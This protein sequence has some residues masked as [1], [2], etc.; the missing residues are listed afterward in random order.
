MGRQAGQRRGE[1]SLARRLISFAGWPHNFHA[2]NPLHL[3][4][5][6]FVWIESPNAPWRRERQSG[7]PAVLDRVQCMACFAQYE[8]WKEGDDAQKIHSLLCHARC[9]TCPFV[10]QRDSSEPTRAAETRIPVKTSP[11]TAQM[12]TFEAPSPS[13][14]SGASDF[15]AQPATPTDMAHA[16]PEYKRSMPGGA[17]PHRVTNSGELRLLHRRSAP[18]MTLFDDHVGCYLGLRPRDGERI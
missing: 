16:L 7:L 13:Q 15:D 12:L 8:G 18:Y 17:F 14:G 5:A 11:E 9:Q 10:S 2:P 1:A 4:K 3:A 6:G